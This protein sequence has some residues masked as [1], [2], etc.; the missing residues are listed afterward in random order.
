MVMVPDQYANF[1]H[2]LADLVAKGDVTQVRIDDAVSRILT[3]KFKLG[4]F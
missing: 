4:L 3:Q 2:D 1:E